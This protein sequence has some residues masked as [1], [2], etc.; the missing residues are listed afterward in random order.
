MSKSRNMGDVGSLEVIPQKNRPEDCEKKT[1][2]TMQSWNPTRPKPRKEGSDGVNMVKV[3]S[4][5]LLS[6]EL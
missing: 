6:R 2:E 5:E 4:A 1:G 3:D